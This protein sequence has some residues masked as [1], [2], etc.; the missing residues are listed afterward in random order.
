MRQLRHIALREFVALTRSGA[1]SCVA[2]GIG[3]TILPRSVLERSTRRKDLRIH[4][5]G[6]DYRHVETLFV[7]HKMKVRSSSMEKLIELIVARRRL[8]R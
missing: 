1:H 4:T 2:A 3:I 6:K 7:T 8:S 5:L